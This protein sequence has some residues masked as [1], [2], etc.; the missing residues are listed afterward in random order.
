MSR[1]TGDKSIAGP[2]QRTTLLVAVKETQQRVKHDPG[3]AG[4]D[5][6]G[7]SENAI[8]RILEIPHKLPKRDEHEGD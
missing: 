8:G 7:I 5:I 6:N 1:A 3:K 4:G 2:L